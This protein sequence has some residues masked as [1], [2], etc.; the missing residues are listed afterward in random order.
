MGNAA[1]FG[2][3]AAAVNKC[4]TWLSISTCESSKSDSLL[5]QQWEDEKNKGRKALPEPEKKQQQPW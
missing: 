3:Q 2:L 1:D 4:H 5:F